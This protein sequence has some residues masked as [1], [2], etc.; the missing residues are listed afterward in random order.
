[1]SDNPKLTWRLV[2]EVSGSKPLNS[3]KME[4]IRV[5]D[6]ILNVKDNPKGA[7][8][9]FDNNFITVRKN[10]AESYTG[11]TNIAFNRSEKINFNIEFFDEIFLKSVEVSQV[12]LIISKCRNDT[13]AGYDRVTVEI[14]KCITEFIINPLA[15]IHNLSINNSIFPDKFKLATI[16]P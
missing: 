3:D 4:L 8:N 14:L 9:F 2:N 7:A 1:M 12:Q 5:Y 11:N 13:A 15:H 6:K 10:L 16:K